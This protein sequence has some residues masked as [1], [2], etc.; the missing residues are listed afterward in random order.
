MT[1][2]ELETNEILSRLD[3]LIAIQIRLAHKL[4]GEDSKKEIGADAVFLRGFGLKNPAIAAILG[5]TPASVA[6][7]ISKNQRQ[8][9]GKA[10][11]KTKRTTKN[12]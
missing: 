3:A 9:R 5:S 10:D 11:G 7:L 12:K 4:R 6:E 2:I 8:K 1:G